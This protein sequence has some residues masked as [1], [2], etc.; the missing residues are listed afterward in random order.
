MASMTQ[1]YEIACSFTFMITS[2]INVFKTK[3]PSS[4]VRHFKWYLRKLKCFSFIILVFA[5]DGTPC[6][7]INL[8]S[9]IV[10]K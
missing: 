8:V 3:D 5:S 1:Q 2:E 4:L 6:C 7:Q 9:K 10:V